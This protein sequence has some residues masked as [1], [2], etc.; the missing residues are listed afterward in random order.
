MK[1]RWETMEKDRR[2]IALAQPLLFLL[3]LVLFLTIGQ[4]QVTPYLDS[5]LRFQSEGE[6]AVYSGR[7]E[8]YD[9]KFSVSPGP[10]V[11]FFLDGKLFDTYTIAEDSAAIPD[12][13]IVHQFGQ[14]RFTGVEIHKGGA[15]WFRG[16]YSPDMPYMLVS[17]DGTDLSFDIRIGPLDPAP[18]PNM[19]LHLAQKL[20]TVSRGEW[21][22]MLM[23]ALF[24]VLC[25]VSVL[26]A[27]EFFRFQLAFRVRDP[28]TVDPSNWELTSRRIGWIILTCISAY[29]YILGVGLISL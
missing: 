23:G 28:E 4:Q 11:E 24:S 13:D 25:T 20:D 29:L 9:M 12:T 6:N 27:D 17:E 10:V 18:T 16:A 8:G 5:F 21:L 7:I 26:F 1:R 3:F 15:L 14:D 19:I 2:I 22:W